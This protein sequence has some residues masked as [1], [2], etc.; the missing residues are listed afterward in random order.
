MLLIAAVAIFEAVFEKVQD[1]PEDKRPKIIT[2]G[3]AQA[4]TAHKVP[5]VVR[6]ISLCEP[7]ERSILV[8]L[9]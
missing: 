7:T 6:A 3:L 5:S 2:S 8:H 4:L 1:L 9:I